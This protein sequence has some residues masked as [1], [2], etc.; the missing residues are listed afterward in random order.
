MISL[1]SKLIRTLWIL[2]AALINLL[3]LYFS[4]YFLLLIWT[5]QQGPC[6]GDTAVDTEI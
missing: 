3:E 6:L 5:E 1:K 4:K 2:S